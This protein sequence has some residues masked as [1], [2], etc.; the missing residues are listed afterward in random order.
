MKKI[1]FV[2]MTVLGWMN[3]TSCND[4]LDIVPKGNK[5]PAT[6][7][8]FEAL[9]LDEYTIGYIPIT[10]CLYLLNDRFVG[11]SSLTSVTLTSANYLWNE[12]ADR[13]VLN[14]EDESAYYR[15]Y[16]AISTCNL[17]LEHV[18]DATEATDAERHE[19]MAYAKVIRAMSY[20]ILANYYADTYVAETAGTKLSVPLITSADINAPH[21]QVTI[22][23]IYD[24]MIQDVKEAIE[25]G[26]PAQSK[27]II[28]PNLG[29][30]YAFLARVYLQMANYDEALKYADMAL[31]QNDRLYDW[32][33]YYES[34]KEAITK[35]D[36]YPSLPS[37]MGY[38]YVENYY[39]RC[40]EGNPNYASGELSI[41]VERAERFEEG[42][43]R[44]LSRWKLRTLNQDTYY[45]GLGG[46]YFNWAGLTTCEVYLIKAECLARQA[47]GNDFSAAM[48]ALNAVRRT[49]IQPDVYQPLE[50]SS[51]ADAIEKI[52][53]T[54]DNE[55]IFSIVPFADARR[56]NAEGTFARTLSKTWEGQTYTLRP[57][58]HL[59]TMPFPA[60]ATQ[61]PGNGT[62][63]QNVSK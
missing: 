40:G 37:A 38:D 15:S 47:S 45:A 62:I 13:I 18:P 55:L 14:N 56:F 17:L 42:D 61:N 59:W 1:L 30:A 7:A 49:R 52:R 46:G 2:I 36:S 53:R 27:T 23:E 39:F 10:N 50:A 20:Y 41:P 26:L 28:H 16:M 48:D 33:A 60:G 25:M 31:A 63:T 54:K 35:E 57:D 3:L 21:R 5:I 8:D 51:L 58:S 29:A 4:Y 11:Q 9:L 22:Q 6:L 34:H 19:V 44:F 24:F 12:A 43:A 32:I